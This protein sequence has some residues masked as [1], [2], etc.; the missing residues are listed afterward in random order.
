LTD[1]EK[2]YYA[3]F[4]VV[5]EAIRQLMAPVESKKIKMG[6]LVEEK[7]RLLQPLLIAAHFDVSGILE[8]WKFRQERGTGR[9]VSVIFSARLSF[10]RAAIHA[11]AGP[12]IREHGTYSGHDHVQ[13]FS[14]FYPL[15]LCLY[16]LRLT[17]T[18]VFRD[19]HARFIL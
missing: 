6:F 19:E 12:L 15:S 9:L 11:P 14:F 13:G 17:S 7:S 4:K 8:T 16:P 2:K 18:V 3:H 5:F 1:L 10:R